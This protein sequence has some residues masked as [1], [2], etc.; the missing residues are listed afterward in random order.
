MEYGF[1][2]SR[3]ILP[4]VQTAVN[5]AFNLAIKKLDLNMDEIKYYRYF[6]STIYAEKFTK[7]P[8][9]FTDSVDCG[10][11]LAKVCYGYIYINCQQYTDDL[12]KSVLAV[13]WMMSKVKN[14]SVY[15]NPKELKFD[16]G[17]MQL[18]EEAVKFAEE[19]LKEV[20]NES[21]ESVRNL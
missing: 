13:C 20:I 4:G 15:R 16:H 6:S 14:G 21:C 3:N 2:E 17:L 19:T 10:Q 12:K 5:E 11:L 8:E 18:H 9:T 7:R 1:V